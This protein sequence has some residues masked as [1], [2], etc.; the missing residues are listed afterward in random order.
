[1]GIGLGLYMNGPTLRRCLHGRR[2]TLL[3]GAPFSIVF[4][5]FVYMIGRVTLGGGLQ[6]EPRVESD[7]Q[8]CELCTW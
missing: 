7:W 2:V 4:P 5:G 3:E 6:L 8:Y 1:M